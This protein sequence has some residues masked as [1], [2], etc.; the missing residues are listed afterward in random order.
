MF[1]GSDG[2]RLWDVQ[3]WK[4][5]ST[6]T[7]PLTVRGQVCCTTWVGLGRTEKEVFCMGT[8]LEYLVFWH[9]QSSTSCGF[10]IISCCLTYLLRKTSRKDLPTVWEVGLVLLGSQLIR[11]AIVLLL[12]HMQSKFRFVTWIKKG[13]VTPIYSVELHST[14]PKAIGF[15]SKSSKDLFVFG[16]WDGQL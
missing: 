16:M 1:S 8:G 9:R 10:V 7:Q 14:I 2:V 4:E 3:I 13:Q 11:S 6:P 15:M 12:E 5:L